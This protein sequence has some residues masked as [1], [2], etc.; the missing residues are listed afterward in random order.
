M[1]KCLSFLHRK[2]LRI[3]ACKSPPLPWGE[4][5]LSLWERWQLAVWQNGICSG[6]KLPAK[7][8]L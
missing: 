1:P 2:I 6:E 4:G 3:M 8:T 7:Y 5:T